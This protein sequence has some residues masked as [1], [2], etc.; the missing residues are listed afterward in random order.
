MPDNAQAMHK[1]AAAHFNHWEKVKDL[2]DQLI[3]LELNLRQSGHPGG[4]RSKVHF[5]VATLLSGAM[6]WDIRHPEKRYGDRFVLAGGH[7]NPLVYATW[8][9]SMRPCAP[10]I[11]A[12]ATSATLSLR[13]GRLPRGPGYPAPQQGL[14]RTR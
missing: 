6:R 8:P 7:T 11:S 3:D 9:S 12:P 1:Q 2:V 4:S 10:S 13:T 14:A 5:F